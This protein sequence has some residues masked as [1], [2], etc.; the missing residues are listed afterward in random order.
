[1]KLKLISTSAFGLL[2]FAILNFVYPGLM[3]YHE[4]NQLFLFTAEYFAERIGTCGG[5]VDY[6]SEFLVQLFYVPAYGA[7]IYAAVLC[8]IQL[9]TYNNFKD[10]N[11]NLYFLSFIP[12]ILLLLYSGNENLLFSFM[13]AMLFVLLYIKLFDINTKLSLIL[14]PLFYWL[15]GAMC[16]VNFLYV[17]YQFF[18]KK[19]YILLAV[20]PVIYIVSAFCFTYIMPHQYPLYQVL[21]G[22]NYYRIPGHYHFMMFF[23]PIFTLILIMISGK[24]KINFGNK[25]ALYAAQ[26]SLIGASLLLVN[27][28]YDQLK[29][30]LINYDYLLRHR[31]YNNIIHQSQNHQPETDFERVCIN[32]SLAQKGLLAERM[33]DY[34]QDGCAGL[35]SDAALDNMSCLPAM[36]AYFNLG[37]INTALQFA[38][39]TQESIMNNRKSGRLLKRMAECLI[40]D[41]KYEAARHYLLILS[42]SWFYSD[43]ANQ[44]LQRIQNDDELDPLYLTLRRQRFQENF[45]FYYPELAKMLGKL[46]IENRANNLARQY[47]Y[48]AVLLNRDLQMFAA[49]YRGL[50]EPTNNMPK[51][52]QQAWSVILNGGR[53]DY[54]RNKFGYNF[55]TYYF[56]NIDK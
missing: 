9:L 3:N 36:E 48:A 54:S 7:W 1:M 49:F 50:H 12:S 17:A 34:Q 23:I 6:L 40:V 21:L 38:F 32:L 30:R 52:Y 11:N 10:K 2:V 45:I 18:K 15:V 55:W 19:Q 28:T 26:Y 43:W 13:V 42:H 46:Y 31:C 8:A 47:F 37:M 56:C 4:Q 20:V 33:F 5:L 22:I 16:M 27:I 53:D 25:L 39:D 44:N 41:K 35:L 51:S 29:F 24:I 14:L